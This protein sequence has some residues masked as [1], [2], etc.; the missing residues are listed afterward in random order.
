M[1]RKLNIK[2]TLSTGEADPELNALNLSNELK[3]SVV[4]LT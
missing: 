2:R 1:I 4:S 3:L